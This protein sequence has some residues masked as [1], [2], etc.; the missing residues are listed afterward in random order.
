MVVAN[1]QVD[2]VWIINLT[3]VIIWAKLPFDPYAWAPTFTTI[4]PLFSYMSEGYATVG[5]HDMHLFHYHWIPVTAFL[6]SLM[7]SATSNYPCYFIVG[8]G[9][10][11]P[12]QC[13]LLDVPLTSYMKRYFIVGSVTWICYLI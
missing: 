10:L 4:S 11:T 7:F 8:S 6:P 2:I 13:S 9:T 12:K 5:G 1:N 3:L